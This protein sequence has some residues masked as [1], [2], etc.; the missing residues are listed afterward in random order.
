MAVDDRD[1]GECI[2]LEMKYFR[3]VLCNLMGQF[4]T[5]R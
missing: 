5:I 3:T 4:S 1:E 2:R